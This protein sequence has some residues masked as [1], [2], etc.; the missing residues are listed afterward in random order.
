MKLLMSVTTASLSS[1][2]R[3]V[4]LIGTSVP[5]LV[6]VVLACTGAG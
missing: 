3:S 1:M 4:L 5:P 6:G 2:A